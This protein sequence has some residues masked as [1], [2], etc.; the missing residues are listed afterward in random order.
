MT[1][2]YVVVATWSVSSRLD[3]FEIRATLPGLG[4]EVQTLTF[5]DGR[6]VEVDPRERIAEQLAHLGVEHAPPPAWQARVHAHVGA[7]ERLR[8]AAAR[9]WNTLAISVGRLPNTAP[10][11][12]RFAVAISEQLSEP[13]GPERLTEPP[14]VTVEPIDTALKEDA[15]HV[16]IR[17]LDV[18][19]EFPERRSP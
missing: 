10:W 18:E 19:I 7:Q 9:A 14:P 16:M 1:R 4:A 17:A 13:G 5:D 15:G 12:N 2:R 11:R 6:L 8:E 3:A